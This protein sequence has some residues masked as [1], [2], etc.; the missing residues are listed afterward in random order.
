M[1]KQMD[2]DIAENSKRA[3][4]AALRRTREARAEKELA[5]QGVTTHVY[6]VVAQAVGTA[7]SDAWNA[8][9]YAVQN[10]KKMITLG[11][12]AATSVA[13]AQITGEPLKAPLAPWEVRLQEIDDEYNTRINILRV[14]GAVSLGGMAVIGLVHQRHKWVPWVKRIFCCT[15]PQAHAVPVAAPVAP[16]NAWQQ[17]ILDEEKSNRVVNM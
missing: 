10:P 13:N 15:P 12:M 17:A 6:N 1:T 2:T 5:K 3:H 11:L 16:Q 9:E 8:V 4:Q 14:S 7:G